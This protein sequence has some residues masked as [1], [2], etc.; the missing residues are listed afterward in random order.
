M[1]KGGPPDFPPL[2]DDNS[3]REVKMENHLPLQIRPQVVVEEVKYHVHTFVEPGAGSDH[4]RRALEAVPDPR[5]R[6]PAIGKAACFLVL[7][8]DTGL[9]RRD[10]VAVYQDAVNAIGLA[11]VAD[12]DTTR[13]AVL[14]EHQTVPAVRDERWGLLDFALGNGLRAESNVLVHVEFEPGSLVYPGIHRAV[15]YFVL[16]GAIDGI[17]RNLAAKLLS[18]TSTTHTSRTKSSPPAS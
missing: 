6:V 14:G 3:T 11:R 9:D 7:G 5:A 12:R 13:P 16:T 1:E 17:L 10:H 15:E 8:D 2:L 4:P 18:S